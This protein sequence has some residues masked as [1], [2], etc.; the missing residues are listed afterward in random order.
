[1]RVVALNGVFVPFA[2]FNDCLTRLNMGLAMAQAVSRRPLTA[3][4]RVCAR[5]SPCGICGGQSDTRQVFF[6]EL[7]IFP[8][9]YHS[10]VALHTHSCY[11]KDEQSAR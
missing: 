4:T 11:L 1:M 5:A 9:Q 7:F 6:C 2:G 10:T 8:S 3:E